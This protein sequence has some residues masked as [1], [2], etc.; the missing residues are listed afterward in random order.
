M[1]P[2]GL[3][4]I[5]SDRL[6]RLE[7]VEFVLVARRGADRAL[8]EALSGEILTTVGGPQAAAGTGKSAL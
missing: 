6:P 5:T 7:D 4:E 8:V 1:A 3:R 2:A